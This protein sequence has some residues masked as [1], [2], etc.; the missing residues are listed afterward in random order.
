[1]KKLLIITVVSLTTLLY[2]TACTVQK[3]ETAMTKTH[4]LDVQNTPAYKQLNPAQRDIVFF[5]ETLS[6]GY[7]K[8]EEKITPSDLALEKDK[9]IAQ[10]AKTQDKTL[11]TIALQKVLARL[12]DG[13]T[14]ITHV[15]DAQEK[16]YPIGFMAYHDSLLLTNISSKS[17]TTILGSKLLKINDLEWADILRKSKT[18]M[19]VEN[20]SR[21]VRELR[22]YLGSMSFLKITGIHDN[23]TP[24]K[25]TFL[26]PKNTIKTIYLQAEI[27]PKY[28]SLPLKP[29]PFTTK[30]TYHT[31]LMPKQD[32]AYIKVG[33]FL[34]YEM[35]KD[36][37]GDYV[38]NPLFLAIG[39]SFMKKQLSK[40]NALNF[41]A[42]F[43]QAI[44]QANEAKV[45]NVVIDLR[46]NSGG[47]MRLASEMFYLLGIDTL[48]KLY[49]LAEKISTYPL[50]QMKKE[51]E[52]KGKIYE[53]AYGKPFMADGS[54]IHFDSLMDEHYRDFF[55]LLKDPSKP[56]F[57]IASN[58][59]RFKGK[60]YFLINPHTFS[61]GS[62]T[63]SL[64]KDNHLGTVVG[65]KTGNR[66]STATGGLAFKLPNLKIPVHMSY[67][68][69]TRPDPTMPT[70]DGILP[71]VEV[72]QTL[73]DGQLGIDTVMEWVI[74]DI[75]DKK[76]V[77]FVSGY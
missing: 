51:Y 77:G 27:K 75:K 41:K 30:N 67:M 63:A 32:M 9:L 74:R 49:R 33:T 72:W 22:G 56:R 68:Y 25:L 29:T 61:A 5:F 46:N 44:A 57:Y 60:I 54:I 23:D 42:F 71:D 38:R 10:F 52:K 64:V 69:V 17:D 65:T 40:S 47:D 18:I 36:G 13:H 26:T 70:E 19:S 35:I 1:M 21:L 4:K 73:E 76:K 48:P 16:F 15:Y 14:A 12:E 2:F 24:L 50:Q 66:P 34:D 55:N 28:S 6:L 59:P 43:S 20:N 58:T 45:N 62:V 7:P 37:I 53:K 8:W 3:M 39:K 31:V 11:L